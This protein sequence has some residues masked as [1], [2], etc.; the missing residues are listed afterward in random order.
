VRS[1][2]YG[3]NEFAVTS[4]VG[5]SRQNLLRTAT[6]PILRPTS[7]VFRRRDSIQ[8]P[9]YSLTPSKFLAYFIKWRFTIRQ[10]KEACLF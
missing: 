1:L 8:S 3:R 9:K 2:P 7:H 4:C 5:I 10:H 6:N